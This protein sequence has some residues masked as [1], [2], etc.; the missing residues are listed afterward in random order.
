MFLVLV[1]LS[2]IIRHSCSYNLE[3]ES[4]IIRKGDKGSYFGFSVAT[5]SF[6]DDAESLAT[7]SKN[8]TWL[9]VGA[10]KGNRSMLQSQGFYNPGV[11]MRCDFKND[12]DC[13]ALPFQ[14]RARETDPSKVEFSN[15]WFGVSVLSAGHNDAVWA[16]SHRLLVQSGNFYTYP[17]RCYRSEELASSE[18]PSNFAVE[19]LDYC[20]T[21][22]A[23]KLSGGGRE[24]ISYKGHKFCQMGVS[25][26][27]AKEL[28]KRDT[29]LLIGAPGVFNY[30][31]QVIYYEKFKTLDVLKK[32]GNPLGYQ[33]YS[34]TTGHF[35]K[36]DK[37]DVASGAPRLNISGMVILFRSLQP[38]KFHGD[39]IVIKPPAVNKDGMAEWRQPGTGFGYA[40][41]G[42]D[43]NNDGFSELLVGAPFFSDDLNPEKGRVYVYENNGNGNLSL[44][45]E[46]PITASK[47]MWRANFGRAI[48]AVGD[49]DL[50][51]FQDVA[52]AAPYEDHGE[53][54][55]YIYRGSSNGLVKTPMQVIK[56]SSVSPG[57][58]TFGYSLSGRLD[59]DENGYPDILVGAYQSDTVALIR[60]K[61]VLSVSSSIAV[62]P[63]TFD[64]E[65]RKTCNE[66]GQGNVQFATKCF[67]INVCASY[68]DRAGKMKDKVAIVFTLESDVDYAEKDKRVLFSMNNQEKINNTVDVQT[69]EGCFTWKA[70]LREKV[71]DVFPDIKF[72]LTYKIEE[73][74]PPPLKGPTDV[75]SL[76]RY[77]VLDPTES[78][79]GTTLVTFKRDCQKCVPDLV[80][81]DS[82]SKK[83]L[84]VG[85]ELYTLELSVKNKGDDAYNA[86][87]KV[88][89]PKDITIRNIFKLVD[90]KRDKIPKSDIE[91]TKLN[92]NDT[93][94][95]IKIGNPVKNYQKE[96]AKTILVELDTSQYSDEPDFLPINMS[97]DSINREEEATLDDNHRFLNISIKSQADLEIN[98]TTEEEQVSYGG[99]V[100][101]ESAMKRVEDIGNE[102]IHK[103]FVKNRGPD[104]VPLTEIEIQWPY[105]APSG[106]HLLYLIDVKSDSKEVVCDNVPGQFNILGLQTSLS[107]ITGQQLNDTAVTTAYKT[108]R[109]REVDDK[110]AVGKREV[111]DSKG[112]PSTQ[113]D[114][115][116][117]TA[118]C[119]NIRCTIKFLKAGDE[120]TI[121][122]ISR[123][124]NGTMIEDYQG[125][126]VNVVSHASVRPLN[127]YVLEKN[128]ENNEA[129]VVTQL[130]P[131]TNV[132]TPPRALPKWVIPVCVVGAVLLL[133][134]I[135]LCLY[136]LG[137]F[138][139]QKYDKNITNSKEMEAM[140]D[141]GSV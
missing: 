21:Q 27:F 81:D 42:V 125:Q 122:I 139:R 31:G 132:V 83:T 51:G 86:K 121:R 102:V 41:C 70:Y 25:I 9:L 77:A 62:S 45:L 137:F 113:L 1:T 44:S 116:T 56:G 90:S 130:N 74:T 94:V 95:A 69:S 43:L 29:S 92:T 73:K 119:T 2:C 38:G 23:N 55:V 33:G 34:V 60:S 103:Y 54:A 126:L 97:T 11:V 129:E 13:S 66:T 16:C 46:L 123:L 32:D 10:P 120:V 89:I 59:M 141:N 91:E 65:G 110:S 100:V 124:W 136:K 39:P 105:E 14:T 30:E 80:L 127:S 128:K 82:K 5:H 61:P 37:N 114:C 93:T 101:G 131:D 79:E 24:T 85:A 118:K 140:L 26:S 87:L 64:I 28:G 19:K 88:T 49:I 115:E 6:F 76:V 50:D 108:R 36:K 15:G 84:A 18:D 22:N 57:I 104:Q 47:N 75:P 133:V 8:Y 138:K 98:G 40:V 78:K 96:L 58:R 17:G 35:F 107:P 12:I 112:N 53:G 4:P 106:K 135:V 109:R 68:T 63:S 134:L 99:K 7:P 71:E 67:S 117:G 20:E 48:S 111:T 52:I 72:R 3:T